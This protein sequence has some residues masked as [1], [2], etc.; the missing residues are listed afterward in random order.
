MQQGDRHDHQP[1]KPCIEGAVGLCN[2]G[3]TCFFN[4]I[5]QCLSN[6]K[7]LTQHFTSGAF[8]NE[9]NT[10][11]NLGMGGRL[12]E[13]YAELITDLW[14]GKF[15]CC[16]PDELKRCIGEYAPQ[17][18]GSEQQ[19]SQELMSFLLDGLHE[20]V[21]LVKEKAYVETLE[22][23]GLH[24]VRDANEAWERH[25]KRNRSFVVDLFGGQLRSHVT[26]NVCGKESV[27]FDPITSISVPLPIGLLCAANVIRW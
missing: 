21:N 9:L 3:N 4:S 11:N 8:L 15:S 10:T 7:P 22:S 2:L 19:D 6:I 25:L 1:G 18:A 17:F 27:T 23:D 5:V 24:D 13:A 16:M 12:A 20:D 26:C 14:S